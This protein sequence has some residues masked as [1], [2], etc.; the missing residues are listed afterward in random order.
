MNLH[1]ALLKE[2][3]AL[4]L[5]TEDGD[6]NKDFDLMLRNVFSPQFYKKIEQTLK[7]N[8]RVEYFSQDED[9]AMAYSVNNKIFVSKKDFPKLNQD[10][11]L[12][13][14]AHEFTH[15]IQRNKK[16]GMFSTFPEFNKITQQLYYF[17]N[18][19]LKEG[20]TL[21]QFLTGK[22]Q[23][24]GQL[25]QLE[26]IAYLMNSKLKWDLLVP[27]GKQQFIKILADSGLFNLRSFFWKER[28][29]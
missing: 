18:K 3:I 10:R 2:Q 22:N 29:V 25:K 5:D 14:L 27:N 12:A 23:D 9:G 20:A 1:T 8:V 11:K 17:V 16:F 4:S 24:I 19:N 21:S 26:V 15:I 28:L 6:I 7:K 13:Y